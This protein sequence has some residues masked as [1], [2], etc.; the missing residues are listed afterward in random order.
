ML[1]DLG[2]LHVLLGAPRPERGRGHANAYFGR[3]VPLMEA[4]GGEVHQIVGDE[5]M[6]I[7]NKEG[8]TPDH[9]RARRGPRSSSSGQPPASRRTTQDWPRFR[10]GVN[11]GEVHAGVLGGASGHRKHARRRRRRE[12]RRPAPGRGADRRDPHR[13]V[14]VPPPRRRR[15]RGG[16][17]AAAGQGQ[18]AARSAYVLL[19]LHSRSPSRAGPVPPAVGRTG[20]A[21][22]R[23]WTRPSRSLPTASS[24]SSSSSAAR[25][26]AIRS[27]T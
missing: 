5:L 14:H 20:P 13:R 3:L 19:A 9:A 25:R 6:V 10:V 27:A 17:A 22:T 23:Q 8:Q 26:I 16:A 2:G 7:Y 21:T 11:S 24:S 18:G 15:G 4:S 12:R 1:A